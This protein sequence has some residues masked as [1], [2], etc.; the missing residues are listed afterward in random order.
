MIASLHYLKNDNEKSRF[1]LLKYLEICQ[2]TTT[3]EFYELKLKG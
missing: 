1:Q 3:A 2:K